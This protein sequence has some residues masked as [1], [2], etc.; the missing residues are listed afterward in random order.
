MNEQVEEFSVRSSR[1]SLKISDYANSLT[2]N[3]SEIGFAMQLSMCAVAIAMGKDVNTVLRSTE[4]AYN[5]LK[6]LE[7]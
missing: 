4:N 6:A 2:E 5:I 7:K 3:G 1:L